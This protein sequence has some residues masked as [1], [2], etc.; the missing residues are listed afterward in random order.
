MA[1]EPNDKVIV[2]VYRKTRRRINVNAAV[3]GL[4]HMDY[5]ESIVPPVPEHDGE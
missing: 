2:A 1:E 3:R 4:T 5:I